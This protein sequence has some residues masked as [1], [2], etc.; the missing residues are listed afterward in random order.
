MN[1]EI[2]VPLVQLMGSSF[3]SEQ[4]YFVLLLVKLPCMC[5]SYILLRC[6]LSISLVFRHFF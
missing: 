3:T 1:E 2:V 6:T 4:V 5:Y